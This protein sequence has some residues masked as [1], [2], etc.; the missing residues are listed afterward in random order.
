[1]SPRQA[2]GSV[3]ETATFPEAQTMHLDASVA[4]VHYV[5]KQ[6]VWQIP[7]RIGVK[8]ELGAVPAIVLPETQELH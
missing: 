1:M 8:Q 4:T 6:S 5:A 7:E 2:V 3:V